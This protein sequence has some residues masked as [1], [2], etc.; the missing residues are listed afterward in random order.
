MSKY[1]LFGLILLFQICGSIAQTDKES[2]ELREIVIDSIKVNG[3]IVPKVSD[4]NLLLFEKDSLTVSYSCRVNGGIREAFLF[5]VVLY[6]SKDSSVMLVRQPSVSFKGLSEQRYRLSIQAFDPRGRWHA[7]PAIINFQVD[8]EKATIKRQLD[9]I[10]N[11]GNNNVQKP[12]NLQTFKSSNFQTNKL[13]YISGAIL[14]IFLVIII[15]LYIRLKKTKKKS[16]KIKSDREFQMKNN[17]QGN[18]GTNLESNNEVS[19]E[20][21]NRVVLENSNIRAEI[22]ALRGQ[23]DAMQWRSKELHNQNKELQDK[24]SLLSNSKIELE[25]LQK[26][27]DEL[28]AVIIHDI[29]NPAALIKSLV[30]L[31]RSYDLTAIEQQEIMNDIFETTTKIVSLSQEVSRI[32]ALEGGRIALDFESLSMNDLIK[33]V[34]KTN[35][36]A[37][38]NKNIRLIMDL[39]DGIPEAQCD[40][41]KMEE[42]IDNLVSNAIKFTQKGGMVKL[43]TKQVEDTVVVE[44]SDNG[45]GLSEEDINSAFQRGSRLSAKPTSGEPS[46]GLGLWIVKK[47]V[48]AHSGRVWVRSSVGKGSTF[49]IS[50]PISQRKEQVPLIN[51]LLLDNI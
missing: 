43:I 24:V 23:I 40:S 41:Q 13:L 15:I 44:V 10:K 35:Q 36:I 20:E 22:A 28:F 32:L 33:E 27:K 31:L 47:L 45:L 1:L 49:S 4:Y 17:L 18:T 42:V 29:K 50:I 5:N 14:I 8:N 12:S 48:E 30:E 11:A 9:S 37:A 2:E 38:D 51:E 26:Q 46:S 3:I 34:K 39:S 7:T 21:Y 19:K 6:D 25:E 16:F